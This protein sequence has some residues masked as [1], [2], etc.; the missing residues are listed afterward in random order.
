MDG[1]PVRIQLWDTAGQVRS[2]EAAVSSGPVGQ[3]LF[4][5][6]GGRQ[7]LTGKEG[8]AVVQHQPFAGMAVRER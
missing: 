7:R 6:F 1:A 5:G 4:G 3:G 8:N 2:I